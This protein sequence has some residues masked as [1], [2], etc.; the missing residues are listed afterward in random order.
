MGEGVRIGVVPQTHSPIGQGGGGNQ[1]GNSNMETTLTTQASIEIKAKRT[2]KSGRILKAVFGNWNGEA[3]V[4]EAGR[5]ASRKDFGVITETKGVQL[6]SRYDEA[7]NSFNTLGK[8]RLSFESTEIA[9]GKREMKRIY[10]NPKTG[11]TILE[12]APANKDASLIK[13]MKEAGCTEA[14]IEAVLAKRK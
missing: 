4:T 9:S 13:T 1:K 2:A 5:L 7:V 10:T 6:A 8:A 14:Q 3:L 11:R 12:T